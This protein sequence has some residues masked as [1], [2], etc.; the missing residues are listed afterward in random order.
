MTVGKPWKN[1]LIFTVPMLIGNIVQQLYSTVDAIVVGH[2]IGDDALSAVGGTMALFFMLLVLFIGV[3]SGA[4]IMVSQY[5]GAKRRE[6]L[7]HTVGACITLTI[8]VVAF[9]SVFAPLGTRPL[10]RLLN[11]PEGIIDWSVTY[12]NIMLW[13]SIGVASYNILSGILRGL[14]DSFSPFIYLVIA[15][16]TSAVLNVLFVGFF[17]WGVAGAAV[18]TVIC[19]LLSGLLCLR[20]LMKM[21]D[22][23]D[24]GFKYLIPT[25]KYV[26]Q[27]VRLGLPVGAS[28]AVFSVAMIMLQ[29]LINSFGASFM[30]ANTIVMKIDGYVIMP[31]FSFSNAIMA[32][33]GQNMGA[34]KPD[35]VKQA[36]RQCAFISVG[37]CVVVVAAILI[38]GRQLSSLFTSTEEIMDTSVSILRILSIGYIT[39]AFANVYWGVLRGAGDT[40]TPMWASFITTIAIRVPVAYLFVHY[41]GRPEGIFYGTLVAWFSLGVYGF[42]AYKF[43]KWRT[44]GIIRI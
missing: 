33:T 5:F 38:F 21:Q 24:M 7:S 40:M 30:A 12:I 3:S 35:R 37:T 43:G 41:T 11:T 36:T 6:D 32:F 14:G 31:A 8:I 44:K 4:G 17:G 25:K 9:L 28:H 20:R 15:S 26:M 19:Q 1:L 42:C 13:G 2:Y 23:F 39:L 29:S 34:G 10:L 18:S 27:V 22:V 16:V